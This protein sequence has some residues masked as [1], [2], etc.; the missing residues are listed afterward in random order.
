MAGDTDQCTN[1]F[2]RAIF[3]NWFGKQRH[4]RATDAKD[5]GLSEEPAIDA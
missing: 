2:D 4:G 3:L 5:I 1:V